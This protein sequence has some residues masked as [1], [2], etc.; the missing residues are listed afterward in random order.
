MS[1][2]QRRQ[3]ITFT[4]EGADAIAKLASERGISVS[5]VVREAVALETW[6]QRTVLDGEHIYAGK[7][8]DSA[9]EVQ[10]VR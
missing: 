3:S 7:D 10:F 1:V 5:E 6:R 8:R 4:G 9:H 2:R